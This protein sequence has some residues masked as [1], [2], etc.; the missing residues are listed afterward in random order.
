MAIKLFEGHFSCLEVLE[1][2]SL[3]SACTKVTV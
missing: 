2:G 3:G 1:M